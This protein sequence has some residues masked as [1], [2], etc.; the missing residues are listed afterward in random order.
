MPEKTIDRVT[1]LLALL[2]YLAD[3]DDVAVGELAQQFGV[4]EAQILKDVDLLWV[5]G[6]PGYYPDDL[7]D[8][9]FS[10]S[11]S[12]LSLREAR[13]FDR[14]VRLAPS[15]AI[16]LATAVHWLRAAGETAGAIE[17][18]GAKL[19]ALV[20]AVVE[21]AAAPEAREALERAIESRAGVVIEYVSAEDHRTER[22]IFPEQISTDGVAWYVRGWCALAQDTRTFRLDR[23]LSLRAA[24][25]AEAQSARAEQHAA[26]AATAAQRTVRFVVDPAARYVAEDLPGARVSDSAEGVVVQIDVGRTEWLVRLALSGTIRT[27]DADLA[28][29]VRQ[30]AALALDAYEDAGR[31]GAEPTEGRVS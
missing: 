18:L 3:H 19:A 11:D 14:K 30:R 22:L 7:I 15:E 24:T 31:I 8:F 6:T 27:I 9:S 17:S 4:S 25:D 20:P 10:E 1:R 13:G 12:R 5:T 16:A 28:A 23:I 29:E 2:G 26:S 21:T